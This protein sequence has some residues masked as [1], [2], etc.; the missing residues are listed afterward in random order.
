MRTSS[1][2]RRYVDRTFLASLRIMTPTFALVPGPVLLPATDETGTADCRE[3]FG[4]CSRPP[5]FGRSSGEGCSEGGLGGS[6]S[7]RSNVERSGFLV[8]QARFLR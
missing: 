4:L 2:F 6:G 3:R 7:S 1:G 5:S 8:V